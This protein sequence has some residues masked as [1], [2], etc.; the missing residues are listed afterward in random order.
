[1]ATK[2]NSPTFNTR[3]APTPS[4]F[5]HK[6]NAF[7]F[8]LT[9]YLALQHNATITLRIDDLDAP[10]VRQAY[11]EHIF[12]T[13]SALNIEWQNGPTSVAQQ[14]AVFTQQKRVNNYQQTL[15]NL[16]AKGML[17]ACTCSRK[18][19]IAQGG[20]YDG[21]CID[22]KIPLDTPDAAWRIITPPDTSS[23]IRFDDAITGTT[24]IN[25]YETQRHFIVRRKDGIAAYHIASLTDDIYH[26]I[27]LIV[28]G[29]DLIESTAAQIYLAR[30]ADMPSFK[31]T[32]FYHHPLITDISGNKLSK[33]SGSLAL[34]TVWD[35]TSI[36]LLQNEF[37]VWRKCFL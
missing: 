14:N 13:L 32:K 29:A 20:T 8:L 24:T 1:M 10:R 26:N 22:K 17:F 16:A 36:A 27:N 18:Q 4:G 21:T 15:D 19:I 33:S 5:L 11:L 31:Q 35:K 34:P 28:R 30:I 25:L 3:I 12:T 23:I 2:D 9:Q 6:G 7:N 37:K